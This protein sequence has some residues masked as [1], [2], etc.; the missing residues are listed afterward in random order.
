MGE[1]EVF[2]IRNSVGVINKGKGF[3][4]FFLPI[5]TIKNPLRGKDREGR[6][7]ESVV[8]NHCGRNRLSCKYVFPGQLLENIF[9]L[10]VI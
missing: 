6:S 3:C 4:G 9:H 2:K 10:L 5:L 1:S 7:E 8:T